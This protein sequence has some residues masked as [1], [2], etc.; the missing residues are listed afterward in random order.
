MRHQNGHAGA[1]CTARGD[2]QTVMQGYSAQLEQGDIQM[3]MQGYSAKLEETSRRSCRGQ[4]TARG[5]IQTVMQG[6]NA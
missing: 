4:C 6:D 3:A 1:K 5:D 2:I